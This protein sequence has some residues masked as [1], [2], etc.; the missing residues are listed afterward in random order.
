MNFKQFISPLVLKRNTGRDGYKERKTIYEAK[1]LAD[2]ARVER[3]L[4]GLGTFLS[5]FVARTGSR[6]LTWAPRAQS[7]A[8]DS[9][10]RALSNLPR[11]SWEPCSPRYKP[12]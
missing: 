7:P 4:P 12:S 6:R 10:C 11:Q 3:N 5:S 9:G 1:E 8:K 2:F